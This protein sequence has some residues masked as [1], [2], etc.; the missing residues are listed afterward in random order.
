MVFRTILW[1]VVLSYGCGDFIHK[2]CFFNFYSLYISTCD[3]R[4]EPNVDRTCSSIPLYIKDNLIRLNYF[5][6]RKITNGRFQVIPMLL[7]DRQ[8][9]TLFIA[10]TSQGI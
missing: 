8:H 6:D 4:A 9:V 10:L 3:R 5:Y 1:R 2:S 7:D